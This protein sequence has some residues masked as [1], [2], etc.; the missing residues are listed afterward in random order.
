VILFQTEAVSLWYAATKK[1]MLPF[2]G[3]LLRSHRIIEWPGLKRP[4]MLI[5]SNPLLC[6]GSPTS[7]PGC[8][9]PHP[10]WP[11]MPAGMG[12]PQ[13]PWTKSI[14]AFVTLHTTRGLQHCCVSRS[15]ISIHLLCVAPLCFAALHVRKQVLLSQTWHKIY[16]IHSS[17]PNLT[18]M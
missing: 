9:E 1:F 6:A 2:R 12:H 5:S 16:S 10:A 15:H 4:T 18:L 11:G 3:K 7:T 8:P 14:A 17:K 13:P